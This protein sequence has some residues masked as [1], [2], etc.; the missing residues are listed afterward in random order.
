M[1]TSGA[2]LAERI[3]SS[4]SRSTKPSGGGYTP[5]ERKE[6]RRMKVLARYWLSKDKALVELENCLA[7]VTYKDGK[8][9]RVATFGEKRREHEK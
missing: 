9:V 4:T 1:R 2:D 7:V 5:A 8:I 6:G 3:T